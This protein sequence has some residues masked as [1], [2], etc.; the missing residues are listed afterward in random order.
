MESKFGFRNKTSENHWQPCQIE[1]LK[2]TKPLIICLSGNGTT[3]EKE[4]NGFCKLAENL[5][6][7]KSSEIDLLGVAYGVKDKQLSKRGEL[8]DKDVEMIVN[9]LLMP[10]CK[11]EITG[12]LLPIED[13]CK[14]L[15]LIT[16]FTFCH[17]NK[18]VKIIIE[19]FNEKLEKEG[20]SKQDI[21]SLTQSLFEINYAKES[22][23]VLCPQISIA[24]AQDSIGNV[25]GYWYFGDDD[26]DDELKNHYAMVYDKP[27]QFCQKIWPRPESKRYDCI[28]IIA[29]SILKDT[30][31]ENSFSMQSVEHNIGYFKNDENG[32]NH[33]LNEE[34][35]V[36][37]N[38]MSISL[39]KRVEN[40]I[41]NMN[42][43]I[44]KQ[45][46]LQELYSNFENNLPQ[47]NRID[48]S[49]ESTF[50]MQ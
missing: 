35:K 10:L 4:A 34:G 8:S 25:F 45:F 28:T 16:F 11:D 32:V 29:N 7:E 26:Y 20:L 42:K 3:T 1:K 40:S 37:R 27:G 17:G 24:S 12:D 21:R 39:Q 15:S 46:N 6:G 44:Y 33:Y 31:V 43:K 47:F 36:L 48:N 9:S 30:P 5:L 19:K 23:F 13:C 2:I 22:E 14:N 18:E 50:Y 38:A 49:I 41:L